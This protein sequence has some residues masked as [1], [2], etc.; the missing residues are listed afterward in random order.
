MAWFKLSASNGDPVQ[1]NGDQSVGVRVRWPGFL[2]GRAP[3]AFIE[4]TTGYTR[5]TAADAG[6]N[7]WI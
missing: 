1:V 2:P 7:S 5:A 6:S 4:F 3:R